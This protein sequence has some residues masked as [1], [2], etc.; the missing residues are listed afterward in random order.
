MLAAARAEGVDVVYGVRSDRSTDTA[1][2]RLTARAYY[3]LM[4]RLRR[5]AP[6]RATPATSG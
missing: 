6:H 3:R 5:Q 2:K 4:R 1:F